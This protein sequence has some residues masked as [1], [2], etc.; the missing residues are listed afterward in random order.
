MVYG[1]IVES[2]VRIHKTTGIRTYLYGRYRRVK[3]R[4]L[5]KKF[6][7]GEWHEEP[8]ELRP[9][10]LDIKNYVNRLTRNIGMP[11]CVCEIGCG[12]GDI[13]RNI[14]AEK[15]YGIDISKEAIEC[16]SFLNGGVHYRTEFHVGSFE[17]V[18]SLVNS[19]IV[20]VLITVNFIHNIEPAVLK[21]YYDD[22]MKEKKVDR[23][24]LDTIDSPGY[25]YFHDINY[26]FPNRKGETVLSTHR[27]S[28][29][30]DRKV[31]VVEM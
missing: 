4:K 31:Y 16:A 3:Y 29:G 15:K 5:R 2:L 6:N 9:Y 14:C 23:I 18:G 8:Y 12:L 30:G 27:V 11:S 22:I 7:F 1:K 10:A 19:R 17:S 28:G 20:N 24:I 21:N 13:I 26:L 25:M